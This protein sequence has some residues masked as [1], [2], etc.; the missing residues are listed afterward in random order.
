MPLLDSVQ[1]EYMFFVCVDTG[2]VAEKNE[3]VADWFE[4]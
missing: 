3:V 1:S 2:C 4:G